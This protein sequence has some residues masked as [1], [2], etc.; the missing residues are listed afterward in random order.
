MNKQLEEMIDEV[1]IACPMDIPKDQRTVDNILRNLGLAY[2]GGPIHSLKEY[3]TNAI[4]AGATNI[5][6]MVKSKRDEG[7]IKVLDNGRGMFLPEEEVQYVPLG[8]SADYE[9][10]NLAE[11]SILVL[12]KKVCQSP[13]LFDP[14]AQGEKGIG[15]LAWQS[16]C[17][18]VFFVSKMQEQ[19]P[20]AWACSYNSE[21]EEGRS[22]FSSKVIASDSNSEN[23][24]ANE[25][26][27]EVP[28]DNGTAVLLRGISKDKVKP[29][30]LNDLAKKLGSIFR[31]PLRGVF[32]D[33]DRNE[34]VHITIDDGKTKRIVA[35]EEYL[36]KVLIQ[37]SVSCKYGKVHFEI[38]ISPT[39]NSC[40]HLKQGIQTIIDNFGKSK[41]SDLGTD[42][43]GSNYLA[44]QI[45][46]DWVEPGAGRQEIGGG[47]KEEAF[48][49]VV[50]SF[51]QRVEGAIESYKHANSFERK[52]SIYNSLSKAVSKL[53]AEDSQVNDLIEG[54]HR[55]G[56]RR[57][58]N[59][60]IDGGEGEPGTSTGPNAPGGPSGGKTGTKK[61]PG[62][63]G[64]PTPGTGKGINPDKPGKTPSRKGRGL[65]F[66]DSNEFKDPNQLSKFEEEFYAVV[67]NNQTP[68]WMEAI[69]NPATMRE[70]CAYLGAK[71]VLRPR[72]E[73]AE[74][75]TDK[76]WGLYRK[77]MGCFEE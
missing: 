57:L 5:E 30:R 32:L 9:K 59:P 29:T 21:P 36:G 45:R 46:A 31:D 75:L 56:T 43:W 73:T 58:S 4:D 51:N 54:G 7:S 38:Y 39:G 6:I 52:K 65:R 28:G 2:V 24:V 3:I 25:L 71:E 64:E 16:L 47:Q 26:F 74:E 37:E 27:Q 8:I 41:R 12:P 14:E 76:T 18:R 10:L 20:V 35:P 19:D 66:R 22:K 40:V 53:M 49:E 55:V 17:D 67:I 72:C 34:P 42:A 68:E 11:G 77:I 61:T 70:F 33:A 48:Y 63:D 23:K 1:G 44:G 13:K 60:P 62:T 69:E 50:R 15:A